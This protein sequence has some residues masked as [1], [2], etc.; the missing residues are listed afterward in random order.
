MAITP[1]TRRKET[2]SDF[3]KD[4]TLSPINSDLAR[5]TDEESIKESIKNI[6]LTDRG[7]RLFQPEFGCDIRKILFENIGPE[8]IITAREMIKSAI[9]NYEPRCA[10]VAVDVYG[11]KDSNSITITITFHVINKQ[12]PITLN[13]TVDRV[14]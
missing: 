10:L 4:L 12:E 3:Y 9:N 8:T 6:V 2:Y 11:S 1:L 13:L 14:R 7:E 5:K